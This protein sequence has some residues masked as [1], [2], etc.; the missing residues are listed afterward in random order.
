[1]TL[2]TAWQNDQTRLQDL[3]RRLAITDAALVDAESRV[4]STRDDLEVRIRNTDGQ[5][6]TCL[7]DLRSARITLDER[8][9]ALRLMG[10]PE[11]LL[12][13][14]AAQG[15]VRRTARARS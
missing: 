6:Q 8:D 13:Q 12:I 3:T 1:M 7:D 4:A 11:T 5:W 10:A 15:D 14:L 9:R 2:L